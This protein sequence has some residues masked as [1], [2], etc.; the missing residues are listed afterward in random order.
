MLAGGT[1][2]FSRITYMGFARL[3][4][5]APE[6]CQPFDKNRKGMIPGEG[7]AVL[8]LE[9][10]TS[11]KKRGASIYAEIL[12][13]GLSCDSHHIAAGHPDGDGAVRAMAIALKESRIDIDQ[14]DP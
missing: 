11:A 4:A 3:G 7:A 14:V 13:Y 12:G 10:L 8:L 5:I 1:D 2:A 6:R 9:P